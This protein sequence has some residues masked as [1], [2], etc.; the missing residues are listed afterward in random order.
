MKILVNFK[1]DSWLY[2]L[3]SAIL[4]VISIFTPAFNTEAAMGGTTNYWLGGLIGYMTGGDTD[5]W[6]GYV[7][8][9]LWY[10]G[11]TLIS[12]TLLL[13]YAINA[14]RG[15]EFKWDWLIYL[16]SGLGMFIFSILFWVYF[17]TD[18]TIGFASI[19]I[20][21]SGIIAIVAFVFDKFGDK[22]FGRGE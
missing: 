17:D 19:G 9:N 4:G 18:Y 20:F 6:G 10:L 14:W 11:I 7:G 3:I 2:A 16:L 1:E 15:K 22:L 12:I 21:I 13:V 5:E 8:G